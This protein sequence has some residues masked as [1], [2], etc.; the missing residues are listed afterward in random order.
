MSAASWARS[1]VEDREHGAV[2]R[3]VARRRRILRQIAD[4]QSPLTRDLAAGSRLAA[5]Q[6]A[7]KGR[8]A[9]AVRPHEPDA[10]A[11]L[12]A[13]VNALE[14]IQCAIGLRQAGRD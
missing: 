13:H 7:Q 2:Q 1:S 4:R 8:F 9:C 5:G 3:L 14:D 11:G 10:I 12:D 6:D